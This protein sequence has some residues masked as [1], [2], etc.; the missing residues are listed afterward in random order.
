MRRLI[1]SLA[2]CV[3]L[4]ALPAS[5]Q[6][7]YSAFNDGGQAFANGYAL[8]P[9][10]F[11]GGGHSAAYF[12]EVGAARVDS[13][14]L[15]VASCNTVI[16]TTYPS[17]D[18]GTPGACCIMKVPDDAK[19]LESRV[20]AESDGTTSAI[21]DADAIDSCLDGNDSV[22][23]TEQTATMYG[24]PGLNRFYLDCDHADAADPGAGHFLHFEVSCR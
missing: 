14:V 2:A 15:N 5:A 23:S 12:R 11:T 24:I 3:L 17:V 8:K 18:D 9:P 1:L 16:I 22:D 13:N 4:F 7:W 19:T 10:G 20:V 21:A 6:T